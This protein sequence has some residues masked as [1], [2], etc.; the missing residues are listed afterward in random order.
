MT[1]LR[2]QRALKHRVPRAADLTPE[3]GQQFLLWREKMVENRIGE[4]IGPFP[5]FALDQE[6]K[7][8][9]LQDSWIGA[10]RPFSPAIV[11]P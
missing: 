10:A 11:K 5:I 9:S 6:K 1:K 3:V 4:W 8:V 7:L 2:V